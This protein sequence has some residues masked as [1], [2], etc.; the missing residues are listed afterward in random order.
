M[1]FVDQLTKTKPS[2]SWPYGDSCHLTAESE[3]ELHQFATATL[4]MKREWARV[5]GWTTYYQLTRNK[6]EMALRAGAEERTPTNAVKLFRRAVALNQ[7]VLS[8]E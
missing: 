8:S 6:R 3:E 7:P 4:G 5:V 2:Q 1:I